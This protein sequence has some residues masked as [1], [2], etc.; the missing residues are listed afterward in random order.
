MPVE[1]R[2]SHRVRLACRPNHGADV[3]TGFHETIEN[4]G[5]ESIHGGSTLGVMGVLIEKRACLG[6]I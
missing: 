1:T 2:C 3:V 5:Y 6:V 4:G